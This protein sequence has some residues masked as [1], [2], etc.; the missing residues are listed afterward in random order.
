[1]SLYIMMNVNNPVAGK[2]VKAELM[3]TKKMTTRATGLPLHLTQEKAVQRKD[4]RS[5]SQL[6]VEQPIIEP[7]E[8]TRSHSDPMQS[9]L[10][11]ETSQKLLSRNGHPEYKIVN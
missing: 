11:F 9:W 6:T 1:M 5:R 7:I 10:K 8:F 2:V 4:S 3:R